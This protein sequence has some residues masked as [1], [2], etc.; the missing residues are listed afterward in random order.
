MAADATAI[1]SF[2][3]GLA[4]IVEVL[5]PVAETVGTIIGQPEVTVA[6]GIANTIATGISNTPVSE[7][8]DLPKVPVLDNTLSSK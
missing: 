1:S 2:L 4:S 3:H 8:K 6:A 5:A 7:T